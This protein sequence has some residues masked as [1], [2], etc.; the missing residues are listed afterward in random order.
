M[1]IF[2]I[3]GWISSHFVPSCGISV[4][5]ASRIKPGCTEGR[6]GRS[7]IVSKYSITKCQRTVRTSETLIDSLVSSFSEFFCVH[8]EDAASE[9]EESIVVGYYA[10]YVTPRY[11]EIQCAE[12]G[13]RRDATENLTH[14][15]ISGRNSV[16]RSRTISLVRLTSFEPMERK[17]D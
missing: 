5:S 13:R 17:T 14:L 1:I 8:C 11:G 7:R 9:E 15:P 10:T 12:G 4:G 16:L 3:S 6:T 2:S